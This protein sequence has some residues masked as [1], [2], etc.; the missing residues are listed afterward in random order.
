MLLCNEST[1]VLVVATFNRQSMCHVYNNTFFHLAKSRFPLTIDQKIIWL[2]L[3][4]VKRR[5][6]VQRLYYMFELFYMFIYMFDFFWISLNYEVTTV[7]IIIIKETRFSV[8]IWRLVCK[9]Y[10]WPTASHHRVSYRPKE[11]N[12]NSYFY[13]H[14]TIKEN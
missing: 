1:I 14:T 10:W 4:Y 13:T 7:V 12:N 6:N 8:N 9:T 11:E 2:F 5:L 3:Y